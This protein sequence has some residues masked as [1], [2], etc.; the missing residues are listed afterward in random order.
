MELLLFKEMN[1]A[2]RK[3]LAKFLY[4]VAKIV[5][6][7]AVIGNLFSKEPLKA[8]PLGVGA[9]ATLSVFFLAY[10]IERKVEDD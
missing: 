10:F 5:V 2:Q 3:S 4:D 9:L 8:A 7:V 1:L 6:A